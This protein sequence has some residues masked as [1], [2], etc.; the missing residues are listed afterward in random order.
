VTG[1]DHYTLDA[2]RFC[3]IGYVLKPVSTDD[4]IDCVERA[5]ER[6]TKVSISQERYEHFLEQITKPNVDN[7]RIGV[8]TSD[9]LEFI[10]LAEIVRCEANQRLTK[11]ILTDGSFILSSY[12]LG[13]FHNLLG[14]Y[15]FFLCHKSHLINVQEVLK[16]DKDGVLIMSDGNMV[17]LSRR[18][19]TEFLSIINRM[20]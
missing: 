15:K 1:Y 12:N 6:L 13:S 16:Y 17:P 4:L 7:K 18:K 20:I 5:K 3:A 10:K 9:G 8:P 2:I 14:E 11:V 19:K